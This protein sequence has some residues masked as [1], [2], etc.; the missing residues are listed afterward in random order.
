MIQVSHCRSVASLGTT[1]NP[2]D[3]SVNAFTNALAAQNFRVHFAIAT[4]TFRSKSTRK[5][6]GLIAG[7]TAGSAEEICTFPLENGKR[8]QKAVKRYVPGPDPV[9]T[10]FPKMT[11][12]SGT[13]WLM[14]SFC[15]V[16]R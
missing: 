11:S 9:L 12:I 14:R 10:V 13:F 8:V 6:F 1:E 5:K 16:K 7:Y 4:W 3:T 2:G 15:M